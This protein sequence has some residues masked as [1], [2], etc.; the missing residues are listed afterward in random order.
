M[1][2]VIEPAQGRVRG[3][4]STVEAVMGLSRIIRTAG[5]TRSAQVICINQV[6]HV[7]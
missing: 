7:N 4:M 1:E 2:K 3:Q 6:I 5:I